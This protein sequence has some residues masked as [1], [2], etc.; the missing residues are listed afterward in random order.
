[1]LWRMPGG[2][3]ALLVALICCRHGA[4]AL[5]ICTILEYGFDMLRPGVSSAATVVSDAQLLGYNVDVRTR[6]M[7]NL[8]MNYTVTV[9]PTYGEL[10]VRTRAGECD[11]GWAWYYWRADR[12]RCGYN[13][14]TCLPLNAATVAGT[15]VSWEPYRCCTDLTLSVLPAEIC[16][17]YFHTNVPFL[18]AFVKSVASS[19]FVNFLSFVFIWIAVF[20]HLMWLAE[21]TSNDA[22]PYA[23]LGT[24]TGHTGTRGRL[25]SRV[26]IQFDRFSPQMESATRFGGHALRSR[27]WA[28]AM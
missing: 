19:F 8:G 16:A 22:I 23:Y 6:V 15:V 20:A 26:L 3:H 14:Q 28:M 13:A 11:I 1:M 27:Q 21:R 2:R 10:H 4:T 17:L 12:L 24:L 5:R 7:G 18:N 25:V 9:L